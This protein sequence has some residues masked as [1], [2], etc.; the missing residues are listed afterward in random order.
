MA[1]GIDPY[2]SS[3]LEKSLRGR[4]KTHGGEAYT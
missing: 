4:G 1:R 3:Y 2:Q